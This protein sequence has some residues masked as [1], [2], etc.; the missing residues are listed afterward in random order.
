[1][2]EDGWFSGFAPADR[3]RLA[4]A[5]LTVDVTGGGGAVAAPIAG[6]ILAAGL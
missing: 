5:V 4:I 6:A 1:L 2:I 3:P